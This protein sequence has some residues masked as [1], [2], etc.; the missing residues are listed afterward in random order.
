MRSSSPGALFWSERAKS[1]AASS[2]SYFFP[3]QLFATVGVFTLS[4]SVS[5]IGGIGHWPTYSATSH[6]RMSAFGPR[7]ARILGPTLEDR[8]H[9]SRQ[10][11]SIA[12]LLN[13]IG[14]CSI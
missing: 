7:P 3:Y 11:L 10:Q 14:F 1:S 8:P 2:V 5:L 12:F 13:L 6:W 9:L 4:F